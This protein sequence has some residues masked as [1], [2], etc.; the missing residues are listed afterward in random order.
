MEKVIRYFAAHPTAANI[1]MMVIVLLGLATLPTLNKET[2]PQLKASLVSVSVPYPGAS[3]SEVEEGICQR[4]ED[5]TDGIS[6][7]KEQRC[8]AHDGVGTL[9]AEMQEAGDIKQFKDDVQAAVDLISD[10]PADIEKIT[11][12]ELGR[13]DAVLT[14]AV[15]APLP[16]TELKALT[17]YYREQLL[18][19]PHI[20]IAEVDG[21]SQHEY[22]IEVKPEALRQ[23]QLSIQDVANLIRNQ[24]LDTPIGTLEADERSYQLR[25]ENLRRTAEE[26]ADLEIRN[27]AQGGQVRLGDIATIRNRFAEEELRVEMNGQPAGLIHISKNKTDDTLKVYNAVKTFITEENA[28]LPASTR[29]LITQDAASIVQDRLQLLL[30]NGWQGLILATLALLLFF[31]WRYTFWVALG[32]PISFL[33]GLVVMSALGVTINM[34]SMVALLMAIG[35]LMDD[36]I[37]LSESIDNEYRKSGNPLQAAIRGVQRVARGVFSSFTTSAILFGSLL[38]MKGT[39]GQIMGVLPVVLLSVLTISLLEAFLVLPHHLKHSLSAQHKQHKPRWRT[40][41]EN[42]FEKL[43]AQVG[44]LADAAI[45]LRYLVVGS[46]LALLVLS[47]SLLVSGVVKFQGFPTIEGNLLV[48]EVLMPQGTPVHR[49]EAV[50]AQLHRSLNQTLAELPPEDDAELI[51]S[52]QTYFGYNAG[53]NESGAH[54]AS[55]YLDLLDAEKRNTSL[56]ELKRHWET[57]TGLITDAVSVQFKE[58]TFGPGG[59]AISIRLQGP[60]LE[61]LAKASW[62]LQQWLRGYPGTSNIADDLRPGKPQFIIQLRPGALSSEMDAQY[63]AT[64]LRAAYQGVEV[65]NVYQGN[66]AYEIT[67]R[68]ANDPANALAAFEQLTVFSKQGVAIPLNAIATI[69]EQ[70]EFSRIARINHQRTVTVGGDVDSSIANSGEI[71]RDTQEQ[72]LS[73]LALRYPGLSFSVE[74]ETQS[75][76]ETS[77]SVLV[78]FVLGIIGVYLLLSLQFQNYRE[79]IVVLLNIPM[80]LVGVIWG[81]ML[82]GLDMT[83]PSMIGFVALAGVVVND[84]I[85]LVEFVKQR[86]LEG[87][88]LHEAAGQAV[89]DRFRAVFLT[90]VTTI[91]GMLPLLS[92]T[93]VQA[94]ILVPLVTSVVFGMMA[95]TLLILLVLPSAYAILEDLGF[96]ELPDATATAKQ[97]S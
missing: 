3:P 82:M 85:L 69:E 24:S 35:I 6:F 14:V 52:R 43:R 39:M 21:F 38:F 56:Y 10:F 75:S 77:Q 61:Q 46:A 67:V 59:Q 15:S 11:V 74:G 37:V 18:A 12:K 94:Q 1:L 47:I 20:P 78:G 66:E 95:S 68:L 89:R 31:S 51:K 44:K 49:T 5:A 42:A 48:A 50:V 92:E 17:E 40:R 16:P 58:P 96:T 27:T 93:S 91:A 84:S 86:S 90:S 97:P 62:E 71:I 25:F 36:A 23:Y 33:G 9:V 65:D 29:L 57:N 30:K 34:I 79:P 8:T 22:S 4:L 70:R 63:L 73:E 54:V 81:H 87:M 41:F 72:F 7:L 88:S 80:A 64:Q 60:D 2:F 13:T 55:L 83:L 28:R 32:L 26:L 45:R 53:A 19:N 76:A